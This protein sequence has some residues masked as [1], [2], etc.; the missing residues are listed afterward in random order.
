V[1]VRGSRAADRDREVWEEGCERETERCGRK[2]VRER[3]MQRE[4]VCERGRR[5]S[6]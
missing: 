5:D 2:G 3:Q 1:C 4:I 6:V